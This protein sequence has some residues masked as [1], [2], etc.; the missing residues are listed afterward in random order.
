MHLKFQHTKNSCGSEP[1]RD[2]QTQP[3]HQAR[4]PWRG[5]LLPLGCEAPPIRSFLLREIDIIMPV[6]LD[7]VASSYFE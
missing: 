4:H 7:N 5:S 3:R 1:A 2:S 6:F